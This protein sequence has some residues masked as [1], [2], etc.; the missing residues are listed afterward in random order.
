MYEGKVQE[1]ASA[2]QT[3]TKLQMDED[4]LEL[5]RKKAELVDVREAGIRDT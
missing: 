3:I 5:L 2:Q 4:Q 1:L